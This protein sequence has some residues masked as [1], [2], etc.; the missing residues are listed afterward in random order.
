MSDSPQYFYRNTGRARWDIQRDSE[1]LIEGK[2]PFIL[3]TESK[4]INAMGGFS[5]KSDAVKW[6]KD[7][8]PV[9][10]NEVLVWAAKAREAEG[11]LIKD[12]RL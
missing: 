6:V 12:G 11:L 7:G 9:D 4:T 2:K 10:D 8:C 3:C 1:H 5:R